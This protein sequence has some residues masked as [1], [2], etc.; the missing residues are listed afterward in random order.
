MAFDLDELRAQS[1]ETI[2][3]LLEDGAEKDAEYVIEHHLASPDFTK[4]E[5][6]AV[7]L[8]KLGFHVDDADEFQLDDGSR[9]FAFAAIT[10][11]KLDEAI[12][13]KQ[14]CQVADVALASKVDYDGWGTFLG[15]EEDEEEDDEDYDDED[16]EE[17]EEDEFDDEEK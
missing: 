2:A 7:D 6:A 14:T 8:V 5:K 11:S 16:D 4:L 1:R 15:D 3:A 10:E 13:D 9:W 17:G 12:L